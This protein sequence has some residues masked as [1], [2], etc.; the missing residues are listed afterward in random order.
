MLLPVFAAAQ[1]FVACPRVAAQTNGTTGAAAPTATVASR[2]PAAHAID[3]N[4]LSYR[5][6]IGINTNVPPLIQLNFED[7]DLRTVLLYLSEITGETI[8]PGANVRGTATIINPK[9]VPPSEAKELIFSIL[10]TMNFSIVKY[11]HLIKVMQ[12]GDAKTRPIPTVQ[13]PESPEQLDSEDLI[14]AQVIYPRYIS[15]VELQKFIEPLMTPGAGKMIIN[16]P[17]GAAILIDFGANIKRLLEIAELIDR[18]IEGGQIDIKIRKLEYADEVELANLLNQIFAAPALKSPTAQRLTFTGASGQTPTATPAAP[19][20]PAP[21]QQQAQRPSSELDMLKIKAEV[22]FMPEERLHALII[23]GAVYYFGL[24]EDIISKLDV[25]SSEKD[26]T[27]NIYPLQHANAADM[28]SLLNDI[29]A[30]GDGGGARRTTTTR[31]TTRES[32]FSRSPSSSSRYGDRSQSSM[33]QRSQPPT[34]ERSYSPQQRGGGTLTHLAGKVDVLYDEPSNSL[35]LICSPKYLDF[36]KRLV[37]RLDQRVPQV[38]IEAVIVE[39]SRDKSFNLGLGWKDIFDHPG[40]D[41]SL[42]K[43]LDTSLA[44]ALNEEG[45]IAAAPAQQGIAYAFGRRDKYGNFDPYFTIQTAEGIIDINVLSTPSILA[46]N[47]EQAE[48]NVGKT[49]PYQNYSRG[50]TGDIRDYSYDFE[51]IFVR[52]QVTPIINK[53]REVSLETIVD[54]NEDGGQA[55]PDDPNAPPIKLV[56][57][58]AT[59][60]VL[61][62]GQTLVIG[63]LIKD[64]FKT[65]LNKVPLLADIPIIKH[66]FRTRKETK[67]KTELMI[68]ITPHVVESSFEGDQLTSAMQAKYRGASAFISSRDR[69]ALYDDI[70]TERLDV[71][72]DDDWRIFEKHI[73]DAEVYLQMK[74]RT[75]SPQ[76][77]A[78]R[79]V[80]YFAPEEELYREKPFEGAVWEESQQAAPFEPPDASPQD[81]NAPATLLER[82]RA[83][84]E[85]VGR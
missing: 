84:L 26:D 32:A 40:S 35:I 2:P 46:S 1:V 27:V 4:S 49:V 78:K 33:T 68:F 56:R 39:V 80:F 75:V 52:L 21:A 67:A 34:P 37:D 3:T 16:E 72:L 48:I 25:P 64:D 24:I 9:P 7:T 18:T 63:G 47:N 12:S 76:D 43:V 71:T 36:V 66:A 51:D 60:V 73:E 85:G 31:A 15:V 50:D 10:E 65:T 54:V 69:A 57:Q 59:K 14:R 22:S 20:A 29:F 79:S 6:G 42:I 13:P 81:A 82:E 28:A 8:I 70:N 77:A 61:Q 74:T 11:P 58:A 17:T 23:I 55:N 53:Y 41:A 38:W 30:S 62:D 45:R 83:L 19:G 44:P 5:L